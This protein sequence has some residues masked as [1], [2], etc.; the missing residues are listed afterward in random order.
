MPADPVFN[1]PVS[2]GLP[3]LADNGA[4][5]VT[6]HCLKTIPWQWRSGNKEQ[7]VKLARE[8]ESR[9]KRRYAHSYVRMR[10]AELWRGSTCQ[11]GESPRKV[12]LFHA[13]GPPV[14]PAKG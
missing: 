14:R 13:S 11:E 6:G 7:R 12:P 1:Q 10:S 4:E 8:W 5:K 9:V 3:L 2:Q